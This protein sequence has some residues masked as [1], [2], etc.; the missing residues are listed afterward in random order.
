MATTRRTAAK[1][2]SKPTK[3]TPEARTAPVMIRMELDLQ[4]RL[5]AWVEKL[6]T[7]SEGPRWTRTD[8]I[9]VS[10][11]RALRERGAKGEAP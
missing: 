8:V 3:A 2:T 10:L 1:P 7:D 4:E 5:D 9:R 11:Q 6:N